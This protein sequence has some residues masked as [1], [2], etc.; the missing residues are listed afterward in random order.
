ML[1]HLIVCLHRHGCKIWPWK[2]ASGLP[3]EPL[4]Q[5]ATELCFLTVHRPNF[6]LLYLLIHVSILQSNDILLD[7]DMSSAFSHIWFRILYCLR[8]LLPA[9]KLAVCSSEQQVLSPLL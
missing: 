7:L 3:V 9:M 1:M 8:V 4:L 6:R 2:L 5:M